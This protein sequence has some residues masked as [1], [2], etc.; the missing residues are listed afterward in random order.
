MNVNL[1]K[2][3]MAQNGKTAEDICAVCS[4]SLSA[5]YRKMNGKAQF[6]QGEISAIARLLTLNRD[7][8]AQIWFP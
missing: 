7:D 4:F 2:Y 8:I 5:Y 3:H 6:T 1:L